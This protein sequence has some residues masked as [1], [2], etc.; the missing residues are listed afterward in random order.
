MVVIKAVPSHTTANGNIML[1]WH[2]NL[3]LHRSSF[4]SED[5]QRQQF[6]YNMIHSQPIKLRLFES[7]LRSKT[8]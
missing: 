7:A 2:I 1:F 8:V 6:G 5:D 4:S 3:S